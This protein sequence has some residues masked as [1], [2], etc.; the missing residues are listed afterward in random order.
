[1]TRYEPVIHSLLDVISAPQGP[2]PSRAHGLWDKVLDAAIP[3][4]LYYPLSSLLLESWADELPDFMRNTLVS[5][6]VM[7]RARNAALSIQMAHLSALFRDAGIN[8]I[9]IKGAAGVIRDIYPRGWR[10]L[11]DIDILF[12]KQQAGAAFD[13]MKSAGYRDVTDAIIQVHHIQP[14]F[15]RD[16]VGCVELHTDPYQ[17]GHE[18]GADIGSVRTQAE[19]REFMGERVTVPSLTDHAW[20]LMRTDAISRPYLPRFSDVLELELLYRTGHEIDFDCLYR[21]AFDD[22]IPNIV[23]GMSY[24]ASVYCEMK[25]FA[26]MDMKRLR[27]W[28]S[29]TL[30]L[31]RLFHSGKGFESS[32]NRFTAVFFLTPKGFFPKLRFFYWLTKLICC[33]DRFV[34]GKVTENS[35]VTKIYRGIKL[36]VTFKLAY[37]EYLIRK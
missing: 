22:N 9:F 28:E 23:S 12:D 8:G 31:R 19:Q 26:P 3:L 4:R 5:G 13:A 1:M 14:L 6:L 37:I 32:R 29:W 11:S 17:I 33:V 34:P 30:T 36:V 20:I 15:H 25:P 27:K 35:L 21:R 10:Y 2:L 7:N 24:A 16:Y 18:S